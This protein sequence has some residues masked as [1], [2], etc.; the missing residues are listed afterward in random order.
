M[1]G[2]KA[3]ELELVGEEPCK[4]MEGEVDSTDTCNNMQK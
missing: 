4:E 2:L 1:A 3:L